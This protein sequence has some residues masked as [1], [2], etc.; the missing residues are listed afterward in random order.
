MK[1]NFERL[2]IGDKLIKSNHNTV[3]SYSAIY[4]GYH[5]Y[6]H[7]IA[8]NNSLKG[9]QY[10]T[11]ER[12]LDSEELSKVEHND[13]SEKAKVVVI[14]AINKRIGSRYDQFNYHNANFV[15]EVMNLAKRKTLPAVE[16]LS[17]GATM[18]L[19]L[20]GRKIRVCG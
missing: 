8:E 11:L 16:G 9:V 20:Y 12:F 4:A 7:I 6:Q 10:T 1:L 19:L 5:N 14:D 18:G 3:E 13:F 2:G 15:D 17:V